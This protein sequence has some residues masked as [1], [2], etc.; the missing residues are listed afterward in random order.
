M[1]ERVAK[2]ICGSMEADD[3]DA[4]P[5][6]S[7]YR[8]AYVQQARA[9]I[10]AMRHPTQEMYDALSATDKL[11]REQTSTTVWRAMIEGALSSDAR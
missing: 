9:V 1:V 7:I 5:P 2:A 8:A 6:R 3:F 11:W 10:E 4:L